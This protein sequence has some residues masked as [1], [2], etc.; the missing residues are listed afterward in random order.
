MS[1]IEN[2]DKYALNMLKSLHIGDV[3]LLKQNNSL[4]GYDAITLVKMHHMFLVLKIDSENMRCLVSPISSKMEK[5]CDKF[6]YNIPME[7][8][9]KEGFKKESFVI[10]DTRG[11]VSIS[12]IKKKILRLD[13]HDLFVILKFLFNHVGSKVRKVIEAYI[14]K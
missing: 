4:H 3:V 1:D 9:D 13:W 11:W 10:L 14:R 8:W 2:K 12:D 5:V 6:P 7:H